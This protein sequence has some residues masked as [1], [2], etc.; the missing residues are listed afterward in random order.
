[1]M[2]V[3]LTDDDQ[4]RKNL[5]VVLVA[6]PTPEPWLCLYDQFVVR[7]SHSC[8]MLGVLQMMNKN[9]R[10]SVVGGFKTE[11]LNLSSLKGTVAALK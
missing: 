9:R 6:K 8:H 1:M 2:S 4:E 10:T 3:R 5:C 7:L 11:D